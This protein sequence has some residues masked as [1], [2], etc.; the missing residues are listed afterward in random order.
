MAVVV[1]GCCHAQA[2]A[3]THHKARQQRGAGMCRTGMLRAVGAKLRLIAIELRAADVGSQLA[4]QEHLRLAG[5]RRTSPSTRPP[6]LLP[7]P[8]RRAHAIGVD[9]GVY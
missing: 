8:L 3:A 1:V 9:A 5:T 6:R 4:R 7:P 2:A